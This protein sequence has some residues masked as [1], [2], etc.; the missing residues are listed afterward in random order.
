MIRVAIADHQTSLCL[1]R[2]RLRRA[3]RMVLREE[4]VRE[5]EISVAVVDDAEISQLHGRYLGLDEPTDVMSFLLE[6]SPEGIDGEIVASA[7]TA[8]RVARRHGSTGA[9]ELLLYVIHGALHLAGWTD[10]TPQH[11]AAMGKRQRGCI[12]KLRQRADN[13]Q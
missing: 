8:C 11:R 1:D 5:A 10:D 9:E 7:E 13:E 4:G 2:R 6:S 12:A 3:V